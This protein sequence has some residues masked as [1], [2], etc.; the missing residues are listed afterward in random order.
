MSGQARHARSRRRTTSFSIA[1]LS[2]AESASAT[3]SSRRRARRA[4]HT[5]SPNPAT[6]IIGARAANHRLNTDPVT[7]HSAT[8]PST[9]TAVA[10]IGRPVAARAGARSFVTGDRRCAVPDGER[11][12]PAH[13]PDRRDRATGP[14]VA[15]ERSDRRVGEE[16][17]LRPPGRG[18]RLQRRSRC[19]RARR[20]PAQHPASPQLPPPARD[21]RQGS[22]G[23]RSQ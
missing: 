9:G 16:R 23:C 2:E 20:S 1:A 11:I 8:A 13:H 7:A 10:R 12:T 6:A 22:A 5:R 17:N 4:A 19:C 15:P 21:V 3:A 18:R 14:T